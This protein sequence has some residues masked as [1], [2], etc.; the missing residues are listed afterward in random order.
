[1]TRHLLIPRLGHLP[2][3]APVIITSRGHLG[4][5]GLSRKGMNRLCPRARVAANDNI[6]EQQQATA[7]LEVAAWLDRAAAAVVRCARVE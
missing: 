1:M 5:R 7:M 3:P 4:L 6:E 2:L